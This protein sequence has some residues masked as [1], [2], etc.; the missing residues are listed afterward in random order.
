MYGIFRLSPFGAP[1]IRAVKKEQKHYHFDWNLVV[2]KGPRFENCVA[3]HMLKWVHYLQDTQA[4][5]VELRYFRDVDKREVDF[6][7]TEDG[8]PV[9][10]VE[11]KWA[12]RQVSS[13]LKYLSQKFPDARAVQ[14]IAEGE[15]HFTQG[16]I[17]VV[18][19]EKFLATLV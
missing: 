11:C 12:G 14:V 8:K 2:G 15:S 4:R 13:H 17:E 19:A 5:D 16:A 7:V 18:P 9:L 3:C 10:L 1:H 6:V